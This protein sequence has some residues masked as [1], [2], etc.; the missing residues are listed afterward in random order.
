MSYFE[1]K[2][3]LSFIMVLLNQIEGLGAINCFMVS[4]IPYLH[5]KTGFRC[6]KKRVI[7]ILCHGFFFPSYIPSRVVFVI[8]L[9]SNRLYGDLVARYYEIYNQF[10]S[11]YV[12]K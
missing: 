4:Y 12:N 8:N 10:P 3:V 6:S 9:G 5:I 7:I 1:I 2:S 11:E